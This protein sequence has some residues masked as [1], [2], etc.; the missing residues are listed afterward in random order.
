MREKNP[1][2]SSADWTIVFEWILSHCGILDNE[3][4]D[5][6][7]KHGCNLPQPFG[8]LSCRQSFSNISRSVKKYIHRIQENDAREKIFETLLHSLVPMGHPRQIFSAIFRTFTSHD[9]PQQQLH[10]IGV[11][12]TIQTALCVLGEILGIL[13]IRQFVFPWPT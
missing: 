12:K 2:L 10:R 11:K 4:A 8:G 9:F 5:S 3:K 6:L 13:F 7:A 1:K